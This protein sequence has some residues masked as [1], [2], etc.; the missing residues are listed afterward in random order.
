MYKI[1]KE[2]V[3]EN[4]VSVNFQVFNFLSVEYRNASS[5]DR[6]WSQ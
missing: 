4:I 2:D 5:P 6:E 3:Q 1:H